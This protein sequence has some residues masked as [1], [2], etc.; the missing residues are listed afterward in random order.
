MGPYV[1]AVPFPKGSRPRLRAAALAELPARGLKAA[2]QRLGL[3]K[4]RVERGPSVD[5][6]MGEALGIS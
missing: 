3:E 5:P 6:I 1:K 2:K 4:I